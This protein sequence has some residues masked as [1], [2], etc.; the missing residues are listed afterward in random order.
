M[1][2]TELDLRRG[3]T[4]EK[5]IDTKEI[6][7][8]KVDA[9]WILNIANNPVSE[10]Q[11]H[12]ATIDKFVSFNNTD[13]I[14]LLQK[15]KNKYGKEINT[16]TKTQEDNLRTKNST[17]ASRYKAT[18]LHNK[19]N[20]VRD[21][22]N[23]AERIYRFGSHRRTSIKLINIDKV[24]KL[25]IGYVNQKNTQTQ[26]PYI[27]VDIGG[28][29]GEMSQYVLEILS[30]LSMTKYKGFG[31]SLS[32]DNNELKWSQI[33]DINFH[34]VNTKDGSG[35]ITKFDNITDL[36]E[37]VQKAGN[38]QLVIADA[39]FKES[40]ESDINENDMYAIIA[41]EIISA[42][43]LLAIG[44]N[45]VMK[46][47]ESNT[48]ITAELLHLVNIHFDT[49]CIFKPIS[50][51]PAN[52]EKYLIAKG[53]KGWQTNVINA[54]TL[55]GIMN[56]LSQKHTSKL[57]GKLPGSLFSINLLDINKPLANYL[58]K[59]NQFHTKRQIESLKLAICASIAYDRGYHSI[60]LPYTYN[61]SDIAEY[62]HAE[63]LVSHY[64][65]VKSITTKN[66]LKSDE[67][68]TINYNDL[69]VVNNDQTVINPIIETIRLN[70]YLD[71][72]AQIKS[73]LINIAKKYNLVWN[74]S[75]KSYDY[76]SHDYRS[77]DDIKESR[78]ALYSV[79]TLWMR[80]EHD[81]N[82]LNNPDPILISDISSPSS[83]T[84]EIIE[85]L[86]D[87]FV[88]LNPHELH[89]MITSDIYARLIHKYNDAHS[90][91]S[92]IRSDLTSLLER[93]TE[94]LT[95]QIIKLREIQNDPT[96]YNS[97][98]Y[99]TI[100]ERD[101][102]IESRGISHYTI[103]CKV[104]SSLPV[105]IMT[106]NERIYGKTSS[107]SLYHLY[108]QILKPVELQQ[109]D[110]IIVENELIVG[111][112][113]KQ[114]THMSKDQI[115]EYITQQILINSKSFVERLY[116]YS[117]RDLMLSNERQYKLFEF[118]KFIASI[119]THSVNVKDNIY[120]VID[121]TALTRP[122]TVK[123]YFT[124][125]CIDLDVSFGGGY[126]LSDLVSND[127]TVLSRVL[128]KP[129]N[130]LQT[131]IYHSTYDFTSK[132]ILV[133]KMFNSVIHHTVS[134]IAQLLLNI[135]DYIN[136]TIIAE[137]NSHI[138]KAYTAYLLLPNSDDSDDVIKD[139]TSNGLHYTIIDVKA[140]TIIDRRTSSKFT[141]NLRTNKDLYKL[142]V[143]STS[144]IQ[145]SSLPRAII[146]KD[147]LALY[148]DKYY[149]IERD[150]FVLRCISELK[151]AVVSL[152]SEFVIKDKAVDNVVKIKAEEL[153]ID[154]YRACIQKI[155]ESV[156]YD[157]GSQ[158]MIPYVFNISL[159][160]F[161]DYGF[162]SLSEKE[163]NE[164]SHTI[165]NYINILL[166]EC[167]KYKNV[168]SIDI[169]IED[170]VIDSTE[171]YRFKLNRKVNKRALVDGGKMRSEKVEADL[172][173]K[174][175][176]ASLNVK[177]HIISVSR[178]KS[179][180]SKYIL[181]CGTD[182][183]FEEMLALSLVRYAF[184]LCNRKYID[185]QLE[186]QLNSRILSIPIDIVNFANITADLLGTPFSFTKIWFSQ[187]HDIDQVFGSRDLPTKLKAY[188][189]NIHYMLILPRSED[190]IYELITTIFTALNNIINIT[191]TIVLPQ[192]SH[193]NKEITNRTTSLYNTTIESIASSNYLVNSAHEKLLLVD[194]FNEY[195]LRSNINVY[196]LSNDK[197][198]TKTYF[199][200]I[201]VQWK[202]ISSL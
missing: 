25:D 77:Q 163:Y 26:Q 177:L 99:S 116:C 4:F 80:L 91:L 200:D 69:F 105:G 40:N 93:F 158:S 154:K 82:I 106:H 151:K 76:K 137:N 92:V 134:Q 174:D 182:S 126:T 101:Y 70:L 114:N 39:A 83:Y 140:K 3:N 197:T 175:P 36:V 179:L 73:I 98:I 86:L 23:P 120:F 42:I 128:E 115:K 74:L 88:Y 145:N 14:T 53:F 59:I 113:T 12:P 157:N 27:F 153:F 100:I 48:Q 60:S 156:I 184:I 181:I 188:I 7:V 148:I 143:L 31:I 170:I 136:T 58:F 41:G 72:R 102:S 90:L 183:R 62:W 186:T 10:L 13:D 125:P 107:L 17:D 196:M 192:I 50:S 19:S 194:Q 161:I 52:S 135:R 22:S 81:Y 8:R 112:L 159:E 75:N 198:V 34:I 46:I 190:I 30:S 32:S 117:I 68:D 123:N 169:S 87:R 1:D 61:L 108:R 191:F 166:A 168:A 9:E 150:I 49:M 201:I 149:S 195:Q 6:Y 51:R 11:Y 21:I 138:V 85:L 65:W 20:A 24:F 71:A 119:H 54:T 94:V 162:T 15:L 56:I 64:K 110:R 141:Y 189:P 187:I 155:P 103:T 57:P 104:Q 38:A 118:D 35:D 144:V 147:S 124:S 172:N 66:T 29:P 178:F 171:Y 129:D 173:N 199:E 142:L 193:F 185:T 109:L 160:H 96:Q 146:E 202:S 131:I 33:N 121:E 79:I 95:T 176:L 45:F 165:N 167:N 16:L 130:R 111:N 37:I 152:V 122:I 2:P 89:I 63:R 132:Q 44:G 139:I 84:R 127:K 28:A 164:I 67:Y 43:R 78:I 5:G 133:K 180:R 47:F 18:L 97:I 55:H